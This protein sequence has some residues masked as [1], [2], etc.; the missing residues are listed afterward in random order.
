MTSVHLNNEQVTFNGPQPSSSQEVYQFLSAH[1]LE[2][3]EGLSSFRIDDEEYID[4]VPQHFPESFKRI[5]AQSSGIAQATQSLCK[6]LSH[7]IDRVYNEIEF[8]SGAILM[9]EYFITQHKLNEF[10]DKMLPILEGLRDCESYLIADE[11]ELLNEALILISS[12]YESVFMR[13][14]SHLKEKEMGIL[15]DLIVTELL[16]LFKKTQHF[17]NT[18]YF[19]ITHGIPEIPEP[20]DQAH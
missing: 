12:Q 6:R 1:L 3:S 5:Q 2:E 15:S 8:F 4:R 16:P 14:Q 9:R 7:Y 10:R 17:F 13:F 20:S 19:T 11:R 18:L